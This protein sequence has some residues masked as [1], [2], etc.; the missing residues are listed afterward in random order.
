MENQRRLRFYRLSYHTCLQSL[1]EV[2]EWSH[3]FNQETLQQ[4]CPE[5]NH[6]YH[7]RRLEVLPLEVDVE[8]P[9]FETAVVEVLSSI[10]Y[11]IRPLG[12]FPL[13]PGRFLTK[14]KVVAWTSHLQEPE[15]TARA[16]VELDRARCGTLHLVLDQPF[17]V[18]KKFVG[19]LNNLA[20]LMP[21]REL[22][23]LLEESQE[24]DGVLD[25]GLASGL[26]VALD[27]T[28]QLALQNQEVDT[29]GSFLSNCVY[30]M[31]DRVVCSLAPLGDQEEAKEYTSTGGRLPRPVILDWR[32]L[33]ESRTLFHL[34]FQS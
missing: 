30:S 4:A 12:C 9:G 8:N 34:C 27:Q 29:R 18:D 3:E 15:L 2:R 19:Q 33:V 16:Q 6:E 5:E 22:D 23:Q 17:N 25:C 20:F 14:M 26:E 7:G 10:S 21:L 32:R 13:H 11:V 31:I 28:C 24:L 1:L